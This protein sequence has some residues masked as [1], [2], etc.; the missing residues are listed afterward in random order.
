MNLE[1]VKANYGEILF[2]ISVELGRKK[3]TIGEMLRWE[4]GTIIRINKT[5]GEAVDFLINGKPIT[6]GEVMVL[7]EHFAVRITEILSKEM[8]VEK[9]KDG[10]YD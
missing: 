10:L 1:E 2:D 7:D 4:P 9:S 5:S 6:Y 3:V 8:I